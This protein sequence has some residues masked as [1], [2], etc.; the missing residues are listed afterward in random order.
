MSIE[1]VDKQAHSDEVPIYDE[2]EKMG[3]TRIQGK[4][5]HLAINDTLASIGK[6]AYNI[7]FINKTHLPV[8]MVK[9][10]ELKIEYIPQT[11]QRIEKIIATAQE[12]K[13]CAEELATHIEM[14]K[15]VTP[16]NVTQAAVL[17]K[18]NYEYHCTIRN[19]LLSSEVLPIYYI[20]SNNQEWIYTV[21][22][23][24]MDL[25]ARIASMVHNERKLGSLSDMRAAL[26]NGDQNAQM[27]TKLPLI[28]SVLHDISQLESF[29]LSADLNS[30][31]SLLSDA[32]F[33]LFRSALGPPPIHDD[34]NLCKPSLHIKL[35]YIKSELCA[36]DIDTLLKLKLLSYD[37]SIYPQL[38]SIASLL[39]ITPAA[40]LLGLIEQIKT[41]LDNVGHCHDSD[42]VYE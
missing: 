3:M 1:V 24:T 34:L 28:A 4:N 7:I 6:A 2:S 18:Y 21:Q 8:I 41:F 27:L 31:K 36:F 10:P 29:L 32:E 19:I 35:P 23:Q 5:I 30:F 26:K 11:D 40:S 25:Q 42:L 9:V 38:L 20:K 13:S 16:L 37:E 22:K 39:G 33:K 15:S 17:K 12:F 14:F